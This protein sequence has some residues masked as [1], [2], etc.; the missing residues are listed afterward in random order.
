M[1]S[2]SALLCLSVIVLAS[3][4]ALAV[5]TR[6]WEDTTREDFERGQTSNL[7]LTSEGE[8]RP[9]P[10]L[11]ALAVPEAQIWSF[12]RTPKGKLYLGTGTEGRLYR[13]VGKRAEE[14]AATGELTITCFVDLPD[15][16]TLFGTIPN[17]KV[18]RITSRG[19][20]EDFAQVPAAYIWGMATA[21]DQVY[22]ATGDPGAVYRLE[23]DGSVELAWSLPDSNV[24]ALAAGPD[25][26]LYLGSS[27]RGALFRASADAGLEVVYQ[28]NEKEVRG[29]AV[30]EDGTLVVGANGTA[31]QPDNQR[32]QKGNVQPLTG[33][34]YRLTPDGRAD[35]LYRRENDFVLSLT[36]A[37]GSVVYVGTGNQG[38][39]LRVDAAAETADLAFDLPE[40][41]VLALAGAEGRLDMLATGQ[42]ARLYRVGTEA[43]QD[44]AY[45]S[46]VF[47]AG[48]PAEWGALQVRGEGKPQVSTRSGYTPNP[49]DT[50]SEW[51]ESGQVVALP[52]GQ[53]VASPRGRYLQYKLTLT[54]E[55]GT[56][57]R[58]VRVAYLPQNQRATVTQVNVAAQP[59]SSGGSQPGATVNPP[60]DGAP[61]THRIKNVSW[62]VANPDGD[63]LVYRVFYREEH[64]SNWKEITRMGPVPL[65]NVLWDTGALPSGIY[66]VKVE[67]SDSQANPPA[68][69][70]THGRNSRPFLIDNDRPEIL[71][72][73]VTVTRD[74]ATP[75]R[76]PAVR[77]RGR[78]LDASSPISRIEYSVNGGDWF[79]VFAKDGILDATEEAFSAE[80]GRMPGGSHSITVRALDSD[81]NVGAARLP[82][83]VE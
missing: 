71:D 63:W 74:A 82:V 5:E 83:L 59:G 28:F 27:E 22:V 33:T 26:S 39:I 19:K 47:D 12:H 68:R 41:Q 52:A 69:A 21:G 61:Q 56:A 70:L 14:I 37:G 16:G 29:I 4:A 7:L 8:L 9:G 10:A 43:A 54:G 80:V 67:A 15:G 73:V 55:S 62:T 76:A 42:P 58:G 13:V 38:R 1:R 79:Q 30:L 45:T 72:F 17:G 78:V 65:T 11:E 51:S 46:R 36:P 48:F 34:V 77:I 31:N 57:V 44:G 35:L 24:Y 66:L 3:P 20:V 23:A 81:G 49:D 60:F 2:W 18:Y 40:S 6:W 64:E 50:W 75:D 32:N 25:G 53:V